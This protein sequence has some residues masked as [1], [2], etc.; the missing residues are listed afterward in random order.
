LGGYGYVDAAGDS[1]GGLEFGG[2]ACVDEDC[3]GF[4]GGCKGLNLR[5]AIS[6]VVEE[7]KE[8]GGTSSKK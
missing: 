5:G 7:G 8:G 4:G 2:L 3:A 1:A 6:C